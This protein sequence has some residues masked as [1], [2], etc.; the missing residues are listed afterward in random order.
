M[1]I[2][3]VLIIIMIGFIYKGWYLIVVDIYNDKFVVYINGIK[4][5]EKF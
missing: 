5:N 1:L 2:K 3:I 4:Y